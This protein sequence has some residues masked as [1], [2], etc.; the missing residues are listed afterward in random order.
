MKRTKILILTI[1]WGHYSIAKGVEDSLKKDEFDTKVVSIK[2]ERFSYHSY[3]VIYR[4]FPYLWKIPF[5]LGERERIGKVAKSYLNKSYFSVIENAIKKHKPD[6]VV[7]TYFAFNYPIEKL[8][9]KYNFKYLNIVADPATF[10]KLEVSKEGYN[11]VFD[12]R[13]KKKC[14]S[15]GIDKNNVITSGWF[16]R[17]KYSS[18]YSQK[19]VRNSLNI[20]DNV[21]T[22]LVVGGSAGTYG[23]LKIYPAFV[24]PPRKIHVIYICGESKNLLRSVKAMSEV[25]SQNSLNKNLKVT[26]L[27]FKENLHNYIQAAD[28]VVGKAGPNLLFECVATRTPFMAITH[29]SGQEDGNLDLIK[30]YKLGFVEENNLK[31]VKLL[32]KIIKNPKQLDRFKKSIDKMA[33]YNSNAGSVLTD[34]IEEKTKS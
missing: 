1:K 23:V 10:A 4:M 25:F 3:T 16:V 5:K 21:F 26:A 27:G 8:V 11:Y 14:I 29:I 24:K 32:R 30:R 6:Y 7:N 9:N 15:Y 12:N 18:E 28:L 2:L 34:F 13:A 19:R 20:P 22:I 33:N 31:A 17:R